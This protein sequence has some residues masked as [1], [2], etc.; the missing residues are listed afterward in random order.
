MSDER[1]GIVR[2]C[3]Q[4]A[5]FLAVYAACLFAAAGQIAWDGGWMFLGLNAAGQ[6]AAALILWA[7]NPELMGARAGASGKRDA[8]RVLAGGMALFGPAAICIV[9]GLDL[10]L[11]WDGNVP[12]ALHLAGIV[13][14]AAGSALT[15][16]SMGANRFFYGVFRIAAEKGHTTCDRGPYRLVRH[17]GYLGAILF[18]FAAPLIL[19]SVWAF[20]PAAVTAAAIAVRAA[21]EDKAL[22]AGLEGY[23]AYAKRVPSRLLPPVW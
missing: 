5:F 21:M 20:L 15:V 17:P 2:Y 14:A 10:R 1:R 9:G 16:W 18:D 13:I 3:I 11:G 4:T 12:P 7:R 22:Q 8:D 23:R 19:N 6:I